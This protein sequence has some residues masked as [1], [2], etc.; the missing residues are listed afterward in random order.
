MSEFNWKIQEGVLELS[1]V[2]SSGRPAKIRITPNYI[3]TKTSYLM[4]KTEIDTLF[5]SEGDVFSIETNA[6]FMVKKVGEI[7]GKEVPN[8]NV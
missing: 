2:D 3:E 5:L 6:L 1:Q 4:R 7:L 8:G